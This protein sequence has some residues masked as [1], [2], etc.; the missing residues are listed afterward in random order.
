LYHLVPDFPGTFPP[1]RVLFL[2]LRTI[3][4]TYS[5]LFL[6]HIFPTSIPRGTP[7]QIRAASKDRDTNP[8]QIQTLISCLTIHQIGV[9]I[10]KI[11]VPSADTDL[12]LKCFLR[13]HTAAIPM[14]RIQLTMGHD[15][16][17]AKVFREY[18]SRKDP[19]QAS[20]YAL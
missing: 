20:I 6:S 15:T 14:L 1:L 5:V 7:R 11:D 2:Y 19:L 9:R 13:L 4:K 12:P 16:R 3:I 18:Y 17:K 10:E 8:S